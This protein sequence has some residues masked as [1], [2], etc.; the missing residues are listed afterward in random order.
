MWRRTSLSESLDELDYKDSLPTMS[1][2]RQQQSVDKPDKLTAITEQVVDPSVQLSLASQIAATGSC[3]V[4]Q[5][6]KRAYVSD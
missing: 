5:G 6:V 2:H 4:R 3:S 1:E